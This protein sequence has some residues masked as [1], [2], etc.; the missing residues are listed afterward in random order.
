MNIVA[1]RQVIGVPDSVTVVSDQFDL[2]TVTGSDLIF[3]LVVFVASV[4]ISQ[5]VK[6]TL[7]PFLTGIDGMPELAGDVIARIVG[8]TIVLFGVVIALEALGFSLG[9]VGSLLVIVTVV[10]LISAKPL[11]QDLGA[12]LILQIRR[13]FS[14]GDQ[15]MILGSQGTIDEVSA[16]TVRM[17]TVDGQSVH[18]PNR[19]VLDGLITNLTAMQARMTTV[20]VGVAYHTDLDRACEIAVGAMSTA[21]LVRDE[22]EPAALV[23]KFAESTIEIACRFWHEPEIERS[24]AARDEAMRAVKAAFDAHGITIAFPQRVVW[25]APEQLDQRPQV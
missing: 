18:L 15:V 16:R 24:W 12:G 9:P 19:S 23:Q 13:P 6:R 25:S 22:P 10:L 20:V 14:M 2:S 7:R 8:Y 11:F 4:F 3:A 21:T 17:F 1:L 5:I